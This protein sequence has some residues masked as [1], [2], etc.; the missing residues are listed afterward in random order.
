MM[1]EASQALLL[2]EALGIGLL[3]GI[4]RER[5]GGENGGP[6]PIGV[7]T[8]SLASLIGALSQYAGGLPLLAVALAAVGVLR[9]VA[10]LSQTDRQAGMTTSLAL[11]LVVVLGGVSVE[12]T[13]LAAASGVLVATLLAARS[14]L[15]DFSRSVLNDFEMRDG[16]ILGV[17]GLIILPVI[18]D[19][20]F[21]PDAAINARA[22]FVIVILVMVIGA[23]SHIC[24]RVFGD[25]LGLPL[26]GFLSGFV[27]STATVVEMGRK[28]DALGDAAV[29][30]IQPAAAGATLSSVS[31]LVQT[32]LVLGLVSPSLFALAL[33]VLVVP[34]L[35]VLIFSALLVYLATRKGVEPA[36]IELPSRI[37]SVND[38]VKF[39]LTVAAVILI[40]AVL[41][42]RFGTEAVLL[43]AALAGLV[44][45]SSAA[46][47]LASLVTA[48]QMPAG[49]AVM[50]LAAALTVNAMVRLVLALRSGSPAFGRIVALGLVLSV[51]SVWIGWHFSAVIKVWV[52]G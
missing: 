16:L 14:A 45:T 37:F 44:S 41:N 50:P 6:A 22:I 15:R 40:S 52:N 8:F 32:G 36:G 4:E 13:F 11:L 31:S 49:E 23:V 24:T 19:T 27:S 28:V 39:A 17:S 47:A 18:P 35:V 10:H 38:A 2:L 1:E 46:V 9:A 42:D 29:R 51:L 25:R 33:P 21:G 30:F 12:H 7:R 48:G 34:T 5:N 3:I 43:S 20:G 26:S